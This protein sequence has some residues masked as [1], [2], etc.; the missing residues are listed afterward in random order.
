MSKVRR[1]GLASVLVASG[2]VLAAAD[3]PQGTRKAL[4]P[5]TLV[6]LVAGNALPENV[7]AAV[8]TRGLS[9]APAAQYKAQ[10]STAGATREILEAVSKATNG[11]TKEVEET[12]TEAAGRE[13]LVQAGKLIRAREFEEAAKEMDAALRS[14]GRRAQA[15]FVMGELLRQQEQWGAA[16]GVYEEVLKQEPGF[17]EAST[18]LSFVLYRAG[19]QEESL[20]QAKAAL[21]ETPENAEAHK[22]AGLALEELRKFDAAEHEFR[23]ALRIK[24]N[25]EVVQ[26]DLGILFTAKGDLDGA[27]AAYTKALR[28][29][30][31]DVNAQFNLGYTYNQKKD[32]D[33]AIKALREA[34]KLDPRNV[35]IRRELGSTLMHANQS[36]QA[37]V[38][39]RELEAM[40]P[41][42]EVC[43]LC[44]ASAL[45]QSGDLEGSTKEYRIAEKMDPTE[46]NVHEGLGVV[47]ENQH[48]YPAALKE[49]EEEARLE[50]DKADG[51]WRTGLVL[52]IMNDPK[53]AADELETAEK[54]DP[55]N[56]DVHE[57]YARALAA[58]GDNQKAAGEFKE[59]LLLNGQD[60][61]GHLD[62]ARFLE[63]LGDWVGAMEHYRLAK[64][65]FNAAVAQPAFTKTLRDADGDLRAAELRLKQHLSELR[66]AGKGAQA[67]E[68]EAKLAGADATKGLSAK[69]DAAM[70]AGARASRENNFAEAER[71][72]KNAVEYAEQLNPHEARLGLSLGYLG[73]LYFGRKDWPDAQQAYERQLKVV[74]EIYGANSPQIS[75]PLTSLGQVYAEQGEYAQAEKLFLQNLTLSQKNQGETSIGYVIGLRAIG[76][77]YYSEKQYEKAL[78]FALQG[79]KTGELLFGPE[80]MQLVG[81]KGLVCRLYDGL[82]QP[83][84]TE[85]CDRQLI[86]LMEKTYGQNSPVLAPT[87]TSQ[88]KA[89]RALGRNAEADDAEKRIQGLK[90]STVGLN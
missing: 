80:G 62:Y 78:P 69:V 73:T 27:I 56:A 40:A 67:A 60:I 84:K 26:Y 28:L 64:K 71:S 54:L 90:S 61:G 43:H 17:P 85:A 21:A 13:H 55:G 20:R 38:E 58:S 16:A 72:Y 19:D 81:S 47:Y 35:D 74:T 37:V 48:N 45:A 63:N 9:F 46:P 18:K 83:E 79:V 86:V 57:G 88:A 12:Q 68:L 31:K 75:M 7:V 50:P 15:G 77:L 59:A 76:E 82:N 89:L 33:N 66:A 25:Y 39:F 11:A 22:N 53:R 42:S 65:Y 34:K 44:L 32:Y 1:F 29:N 3:K 87:L 6:A 41:E 49:Y 14:G 23:E 51:H 30:S 52:L 4:D 36:A 2:F 24:P 70:E 10:L 8:K 5:T